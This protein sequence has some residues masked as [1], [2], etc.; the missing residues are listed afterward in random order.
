M[1]TD[2]ISAAGTSRREMLLGGCG[3]AVA[4]RPQRH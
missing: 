4:A 1:G 3:A 2:S